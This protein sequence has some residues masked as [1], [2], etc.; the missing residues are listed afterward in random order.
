MLLYAL[1]IF[2]SAFL[3]FQI[4]PMISRFILPFFG[5]TP[6]VW[7]TVQLFFQVFLT[8][9]YAY[10][11]WLISRV[12][13][14]NQRVI[15]ISLLAA[16][17]ALL[18]G[19]G[20]FWPSP[21]TPSAAWKPVGVDTPILDIFKLLAVAVGLPYFMLCTNSP[22]IQAWFS[23]ALPSKSPYRLYALSNI[24][25]LLGLLAYPF[26]IEPNLTLRAQGWAWAIGFL[27]F[28]VLAGTAAFRSARFAG[29]DTSKVVSPLSTQPVK[30]VQALWILFSA[31]ASTL[32]LAITNQITQEV[33]AVPFLW[34]LPLSIYLVTFILTYSG[35]KWYSRR[36]FGMLLVIASV[37]MVWALVDVRTH[38]ITQ[39]V[40]YCFVLFTGAMICNGETY[41]LR[42]EAD[43]LTRF[44]LMTSIGGALG[45]V[46][47]NLVAPALFK[48]F[49]ELPISI[50]LTWALV[51]AIFVSR[52]STDAQKRMKFLFNVM[53]GAAIILVG[54]LA[55]FSLLGGAPSGDV[56]QERNF[57][58]VTRVKE[59][60]QGDPE[61]HGYNLVH[62]VTIHGVQYT[63]ADKRDLPTGY[64][65]DQSGVGLAIKNHPNFGK[66]MKVGII[67][68]GMGGLS[69]Y[70]KSGDNYRYY[71]INP[72]MKD[73]AL[74]LGDY[75]SYIGDSPAKTDIVMGDAR[76]SME[77]ELA[78][79]TAAVYD[80]LV[81]DAFSGD[82]IPVHLLTK[83]AFE[84]YLKQLAPQG[85]L[86]ANI[87]NRHLNMIPV[88]W[89]Q[90]Q[91]FGLHMVVIPNEGD[92]KLSRSSLFVLL[93]RDPKLLE[94]PVIASRAEKLDGYSTSIPQW[95]DDFSNLFQILR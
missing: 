47:V 50:G 74:G 26:L 24:G 42:P 75:F 44:Y 35:E 92:G 21:V 80:V 78:D 69:A 31:V 57:Y 84:V 85:I 72:I 10:S 3:L 9:G 8:V 66:G 45:G 54:G 30:R 12:S 48:G 77:R 16:G 41:R 27:L 17:V 55:M 82:S 22:L 4:Q 62:G 91:D 63:A 89:K 40:I 34:V 86:A 39:I 15:H 88:F 19:L 65:A 7:S 51:L 71:E 59:I 2:I 33:A 70:G 13:V 1:C 5:G 6:M 37:A 23:K 43:R 79:G 95:T 76:I 20:Y 64:Y 90:A 53:V 18:A 36:L 94:N 83:E 60:G 73:L 46:F 81:M 67:G 52:R 29:I 93:S 68:L 61:W 56:F 11:A 87:S 32:L 58:G 14:K 38:F 49:W 25:S 28:A